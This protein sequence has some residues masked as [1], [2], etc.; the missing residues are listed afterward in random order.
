V[1]S[2]CGNQGHNAL[3]C[4]SESGR[5]KRAV[6][7][8]N[9]LLNDGHY[10]GAVDAL[11]PFKDTNALLPSVE[12]DVV[13]WLSECYIGLGDYDA[14]LPYEE[15]KLQ[16]TLDHSEL[17]GRGSAKHAEALRG[18]CTVYTGLKRFGEAQ[19][20]IDCAIHIM[21][22]LAL[23]KTVEYGAMLL[24]K[25]TLE[26]EQMRSED[27]LKTYKA[28]QALL[29]TNSADYAVVCNNIGNCYEEKKETQRAMAEY[30]SARETHARVGGKDHPDYSCATY[31]I[32]RMHL[33]R[34]EYRE[35]A[36]LLEEALPVYQREFGE[37]HKDTVDLRQDLAAAKAAIGGDEEGE[38]DNVVAS[39]P[40]RPRKDDEHQEL[41]LSPEAAESRKNRQRK[42][43]AA[44][45]PRA[46]SELAD[47]D[48]DS[49]PKKSKTQP[50]RTQGVW[51]SRRLRFLIQRSQARRW[52]TATLT[53]TQRR[54]ALSP[55]TGSARSRR[56]TAKRHSNSVLRSLWSGLSKHLSRHSEVE[57]SH[58][59]IC[60]SWKRVVHFPSWRSGRRQGGSSQTRTL[61]C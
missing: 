56:R 54:T 25:G 5:A 1:C 38:V 46:E 18:L 51:C 61:S 33:L 35:A 48:S 57:L 8:A 20:R 4:R 14:A 39:L 28:A 50:H 32:A 49:Q 31:N 11:Q 3:R 40:K 10:Q 30:R 29:P 15:R 37:G 43:P 36:E 47:E 17:G 21:A 53:T 9:Q 22:E 7:E 24:E 13:C 44:S 23:T 60:G 41:Q 45:P 26:S 19:R 52:S 12:R 42:L 59:R 2:V 16:L 34:K 58:C 6:K 55:E 27:A